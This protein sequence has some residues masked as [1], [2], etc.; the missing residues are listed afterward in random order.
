MSTKKTSTASDQAGK[1]LQDTLATFSSLPDEAFVRLPVVRALRANVCSATIWRHVKAGLLPE[2]VKLSAGVTAWRVGD[3]RR[4]SAQA[5]G[6][7]S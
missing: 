7:A 6:Q 5:A 1:G 4:Y 3:L 2:P